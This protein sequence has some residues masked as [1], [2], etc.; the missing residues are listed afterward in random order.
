[1]TQTR[2]ADSPFEA[3]LEVVATLADQAFAATVEELRK[4]DELTVAL[5]GML[6]HG[7]SVDELSAATGL[8]P[9]E[10]RKRTKRN[11]RLLDD[12]VNELAG[13]G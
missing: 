4:Y 12:D 10:I 5:R 11:L 9:Q 3:Q 2:F 8:T 7:V 13:I 6:K 1:M